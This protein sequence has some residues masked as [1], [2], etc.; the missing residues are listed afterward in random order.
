MGAAATPLK[1]WDRGYGSQTSSACARGATDETHVGVRVEDITPSS[2]VARSMGQMETFFNLPGL[3]LPH[4]LLSGG[5]GGGLLPRVPQLLAR[6]SENPL[7]G[8]S[9]TTTHALLPQTE[10]ASP[11]AIQSQAERKDR[12]QTEKIG[13]CL[14]GL[15]RSRMA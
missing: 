1:G 11:P 9:E 13:C 2:K 8:A 14:K 5:P 7:P 4:L 3:R 10:E 6:D 12:G 15:A